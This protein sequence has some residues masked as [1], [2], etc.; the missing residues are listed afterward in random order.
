MLGEDIGQT[1]GRAVGIMHLSLAHLSLEILNSGHLGIGRLV[2]V[3]LLTEV[4]QQFIPKLDEGMGLH[5]ER[6]TDMIGHGLTV[7]LNHMREIHKGIG[8]LARGV[9]HPCFLGLT[10]EPTEALADDGTADIQDKVGDIAL[11]VA[12][13]HDGL[14]HERIHGLAANE[15]RALGL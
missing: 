13:Q 5:D 3:S 12:Y 11:V 1:D 2:G 14:V 15:H 7:A 10:Q 9:D 4:G 8:D 6:I